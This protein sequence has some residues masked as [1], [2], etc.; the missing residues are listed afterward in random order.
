MAVQVQVA[1]VSGPTALIHAYI[2]MGNQPTNYT[3]TYKHADAFLDQLC[4]VYT[5]MLYKWHI[6]QMNTDCNQW[7]PTQT[8]THYKQMV[9]TVCA[10]HTHTHTIHAFVIQYT[11]QR[12]ALIVAAQSCRGWTRAVSS[13]TLSAFWFSLGTLP[14]CHWGHNTCSRFGEGVVQWSPLEALMNTQ[15]HLLAVIVAVI[16][17]HTSKCTH[18][19]SP[20]PTCRHCN[21]LNGLL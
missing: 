20:T 12:C 18:P 8:R 6:Q 19:P 7:L 11:T 9:H 13:L 16:S 15:K 10:T 5:Y 1:H 21:L 3:H 17:L 4:L 2:H 14:Y